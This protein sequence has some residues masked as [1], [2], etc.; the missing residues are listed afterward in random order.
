MEV[1]VGFEREGL[2]DRE[3]DEVG[4]EEE[5]GERGGSGGRGRDRGRRGSR[6]REEYS[7]LQRSESSKK[8]PVKSIW[9]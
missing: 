4:R 1:Q 5:R 2:L 3:F 7:R 6:S 8:E 9:D